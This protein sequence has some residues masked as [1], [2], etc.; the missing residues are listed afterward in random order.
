MSFLK[1]IFDTWL[2]DF[3]TFGIPHILKSFKCLTIF[4][5]WNNK[6]KEINYYRRVSFALWFMRPM[7]W[8][9]FVV[10]ISRNSLTNWKESFFLVLFFV[11][12]VFRKYYI[13]R[14]GNYYLIS[15]SVSNSFHS[16]ES[17]TVAVA[18]ARVVVVI[19][20][21]SIHLKITQLLFVRQVY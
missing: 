2:K 1:I 7:S 3:Q 10:S 12:F 20:I 8:R 11:F 15:V 9:L 19:V 17:V 16:K 21:D 5:C 4:H 18:F 6:W 14:P 13:F